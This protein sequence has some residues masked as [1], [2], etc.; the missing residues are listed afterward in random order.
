VTLGQAEPVRLV[1]WDLDDTF[2][3]GTLSE[4]GMIY[5]PAHHDIV[6]TLARRGIVNSIC[7]KNDQA[8]VRAVLVQ[9]GIWDSFI[10]PSINWEPKGP[11]LA[12]LVE[13]V[14]LRPGTI[15]FIDD[16]AMNRA[17]AAHFVPGIQV[18]DET[19]IPALLD[20]PRLRGKDDEGLTRLAQYKMLERRQKDARAAS[21]RGDN[22]E[23]LRG[24]HIRVSIEHDLEPHID[25]AIEL[26]N[27]TN[28]LN[29]TKARLPEDIALA[30]A[31]LR[32]LLGG[33]R[34]QAG[35]V[36]LRDDYGDYGFCGLYVVHTG[37]RKRLVHFC[38]SCRIMGMGVERWLFQHLGRPFLR[39]EG[40]VAANPGR[41]RSPVDWITAEA[42]DAACGSGEAPLLIDYI[43]ARGGC[44]LNAVT[45]YFNMAAG[46]VVRDFSFARDGVNMRVDHSMFARYALE[47]ISQEAR[48]AFAQLGY[49]DED[50]TTRM[51]GLPEGKKGAWVLSFWAD[52]GCALYRHRATGLSVPVSMP[53]LQPG[54]RDV[55]TFDLTAPQYAAA[56]PIARVLQ[57]D[58]DFTGMIG[59]AAFK[60]NMRLILQSAVPGT[61]VFIL[62]ANE[63]V[64]RGGKVLISPQKRA[65]NTWVSHVAAEF[66]CVSLVDTMGFI[67][68]D[69]EVITNSHF[70]RMVYFRIF[71]YIQ[72]AIQGD[73]RGPG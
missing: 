53:A 68:H 56:L 37:T 50:Y 20:D 18:A 9:H 46:E 36:R 41:D 48:T 14:Q 45:H 5:Q 21:V 19:V 29:Y 16:N 28:Q 63:H 62:M 57:S 39:I 40:K 38:F 35:L 1:I 10:F 13:S 59:E 24:S 47:G 23:F 12:A 64:R 30:R 73:A 15:L 22:S 43:Y 52:A 66:D 3:S 67:A 55:A 31:E 17:E 54:L 25:R 71:E 70:D 65:L 34:M 27:R 4:G 11:R 6:L 61:R 58:Y 44:D 2:W 69:K 26:I 8:S 32:H 49:R 60:L 51:T 42:P 72:K 7:S 33:Y